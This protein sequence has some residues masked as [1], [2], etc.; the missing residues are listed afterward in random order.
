M[1]AGGADARIQLH[2]SERAAMVALAEAEAALGVRGSDSPVL[3][4][5]GGVRI[6]LPPPLEVAP[7]VAAVAAATTMRS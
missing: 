3:G 2:P 5:G 1:G 6:R 4:S 7:W